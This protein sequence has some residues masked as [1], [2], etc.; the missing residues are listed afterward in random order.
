ML[1]LS[2]RTVLCMCLILLFLVYCSN[3]PS[4]VVE[5][6]PVNNPPVITSTPPNQHSYI[7]FYTYTPE[8]SD[9]D[10]DPL[11]YS[12]LHPDFL[13]FDEESNVLQ[14]QTTAADTGSYNIVI[15]VSDGTD[16]TIQSYTLS[17]NPVS[18]RPPLITTTPILES[19][20]GRPYTYSLNAHDPDGDSL[21]ITAA[22][23]AWLS[24]DSETGVLH[25]TP[26]WE[27]IGGHQ[28]SFV[29]TDGEF[30]TIQSFQL[31]VLLGEIVCEQDFGDPDSSEY[32]LP[33][34]AGYSFTC[35]Q[36]NCNPFGGHNNTFAY[37][38]DTQIGDTIIASR[39]GLVFFV[40]EQYED[41]D[42]VSGHENNVFIE[43]DDGTAAR[44]THL[45]KDG[46]LVS[47]GN[48]CSAGRADRH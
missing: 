37:D 21:Q 39:G 30:N 6:S 46:A 20:Y 1:K 23:P 7:D 5:T 31:I 25:G 16:S 3:E 2:V 42:I 38:F 22:H 27:N 4:S 47:A 19:D 10:G 45:A 9:P 8:A 11:F 14:G 35:I 36:G 41:G 15:T 26:A 13:S 24:F 32:I 28:V 43:H 29:V 48:A 44:Y 17:V 34:K 33:F 40:N 12:S 18:N